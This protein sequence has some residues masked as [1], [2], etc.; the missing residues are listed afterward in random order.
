MGVGRVSVEEKLEGFRPGFKKEDPG[1]TGE[2][3]QKRGSQNQRRTE[4]NVA[5]QPPATE[6]HLA[7]RLGPAATAVPNPNQEAHPHDIQETK[8]SSKEHSDQ[9]GP[10]GG[11]QAEER[12]DGGEEFD[13]PETESFLT[14]KIGKQGPDSK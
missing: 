13:V 5:A 1:G 6:K 10:Q 11:L 8:E 3:K 12:S 4:R 9:E 14:K 7:D 2:Q